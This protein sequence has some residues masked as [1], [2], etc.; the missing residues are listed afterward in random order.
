MH[1]SK[2][3]TIRRRRRWHLG[4]L[5]RYPPILF[6]SRMLV[7][8]V[9]GAST[10]DDKTNCHAR[11]GCQ[12]PCSSST[13]GESPPSLGVLDEQGNTNGNARPHCRRHWSN[14]VYS[15]DEQNNAVRPS[16]GGRGSTSRSDASVVGRGIDSAVLD[17]PAVVVP[18]GGG[19]NGV[20]FPPRRPGSSAPPA[21]PKAR[22]S[23]SSSAAFR[24]TAFGG[25]APAASGEQEPPASTSGGTGVSTSGGTRTTAPSGTG[26]RFRRGRGPG[27]AWGVVTGATATPLNRAGDRDEQSDVDEGGAVSSDSDEGANAAGAPQIGRFRGGQFRLSDLRA[28]RTL[29]RTLRSRSQPVSNRV[30][31]I[32]DEDERDEDGSDHVSA[33]RDGTTTPLGTSAQQEETPPP[34]TTTSSGASKAR[35]KRRSRAVRPSSMPAPRRRPRIRRALA[36]DESEDEWGMMTTDNEAYVGVITMSCRV[37]WERNIPSPPP[38]SLQ[39]PSPNSFHHP[40]PNALG[41]V[42]SSSPHSSLPFFQRVHH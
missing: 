36:G 1:P 24:G 19:R 15:E 8:F 42:S 2:S 4:F 25:A 23:A 26:S 21:L 3:K 41:H 9:T 40:S 16:N 5:L 20:F 32:G 10:P 31:P 30:Q 17:P 12:Q 39:H 11:R 6:L 18:D 35:P 33:V 37:L 28:R 27:P 34:A 14:A 38:D 7:S 22:S 13:P 29:Q